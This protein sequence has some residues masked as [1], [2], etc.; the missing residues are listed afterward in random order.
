MTPFKV[1]TSRSGAEDDL[2]SAFINLASTDSSLRIVT[3]SNLTTSY[4][5][6]EILRY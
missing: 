5:L 4:M 3:K 1:V 2:L 6:L